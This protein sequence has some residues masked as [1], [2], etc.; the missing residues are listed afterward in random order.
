MRRIEYLA[1]VEAMRGNLSGNQNLKYP[2][3]N[4]SAWNS[5]SDRRNYATNYN[6]RYIG[7]KRNSTGLKFFSVKTKA[8]V[9]MSPAIRLQ[10]AVLSVGSV[11][12]NIIGGDL[13]TLTDIQQLFKASQEYAQG[14]TIKRWI[15][16]YVRAALKSK[17]HIVFPTTGSGAVIIYTNPYISAAAPAQ[18]YD[19][20]DFF[21]TDLLVKFWLQLADGNPVYFYIDGQKGLAREGNT[22]SNI[23]GNSY[24]N[25]LG[26][27]QNTIGPNPYLGQGEGIYVQLNGVY[28]LF[29]ETITAGG[30]YTTTTIAPTPV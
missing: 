9:N 5:P 12:S 16:T 20:K 28:I 15:S 7:N 29:T 14:W 24:L 18:S 3:Q 2:T 19:I 8:A 1:P 17:R 4:N 10:Q 25:I 21:P 22:F 26:I 27:T 11:V 30:K 23:Q 13:R 6:T